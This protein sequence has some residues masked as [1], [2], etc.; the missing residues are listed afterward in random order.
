MNRKQIGNLYHDIN[1]L[2]STYTHAIEARWTLRRAGGLAAVLL[3]AMSGLMAQQ[4]H[5]RD[6]LRELRTT[7]NDQLVSAQKQIDE[8]A[9]L[10]RERAGLQKQ[11]AIHRQLK[12]PIDYSHITGT[13][14]E[15]PTHYDIPG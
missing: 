1:F 10:Q 7:Y 11:L 3:T 8:Y 15:G 5:N 6:T 9:R 4:F 12:L 2:P 14:A 13:L